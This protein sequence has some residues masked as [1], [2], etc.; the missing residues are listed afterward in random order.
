LK[1]KIIEEEG[2]GGDKL[3]EEYVLESLSL[4]EDIRFEI[5]RD[6]E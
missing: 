2:Q 6:L 5:I 4:C 3:D 1:I